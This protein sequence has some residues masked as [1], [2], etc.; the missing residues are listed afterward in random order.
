MSEENKGFIDKVK[1]KIKE[2]K[3]EI[4]IVGVTVVTVVGAVLITKNWDSIKRLVFASDLK[5]NINKQK[6]IILMTTA[7]V[8]VC[9][10]ENVTIESI[11]RAVD[12]NKHIRNLPEGWNASL[13][14]IES[15]LEHGFLLEEHQ[16]WVDTYTKMCA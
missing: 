3:T 12:V 14:K 9:I 1:V 2:H 4:I 6:D 16:T 8:N 5:N 11:E 7:P 13:S 15:A 10:T